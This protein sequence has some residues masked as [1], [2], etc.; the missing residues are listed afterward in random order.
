[1]AYK[2]QRMEHIILSL[3]K[4]TRN[5][6]QVMNQ[7]KEFRKKTNTKTGRRM[8]RHLNKPNEKQS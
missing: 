6:S 8:D 4:M 5:C 1:M 7:I 3:E 2:P